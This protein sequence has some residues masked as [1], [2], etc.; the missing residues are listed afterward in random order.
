MGKAA[1]KGRISVPM[2]TIRSMAGSDAMVGQESVRSRTQ[3]YAQ[4]RKRNVP[5][6]KTVI[7]EVSLPARLND[8][9]PAASTRSRGRRSAR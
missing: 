6:T 7:K 1:A 4:D 2:T 3:W 8:S 5:N 9:A